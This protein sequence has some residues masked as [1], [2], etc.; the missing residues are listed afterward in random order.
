MKLSSFHIVVSSFA[1]IAGVVIA[2]YQALAPKSDPQPLQVNVALGADEANAA[3]KQ[4]GGPM[5]QTNA[6]ALE[7]NARIMAALKDGSETRY[8]FAALFDGRPDTHVTVQPPDAELNI[9]VEFQSAAA[10]PVTAIQYTPPAGASGAL[11]ST[12]DV[13]V[14]PEG[15]I[16]ASGRPVMNYTL[17]QS[18]EA[19]TFAVPGHTT[20]KAVWLRIAGNG[21][22]TPVTIGDFSILREQLTP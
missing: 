19:Q 3:A 2:G 5:L 18:D 1:A 20:G 16:E 9:L 7:R 22:G 11:A 8:D 13:M 21:D 10:Q 12:L 14:L 6:V 15:Q 17:Q 4:D